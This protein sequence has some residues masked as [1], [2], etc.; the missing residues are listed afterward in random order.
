MQFPSWLSVS[1]FLFMG[2]PVIIAVISFVIW[3][4]LFRAMGW[5]IFAR[6]Q[7]ATAALFFLDLWMK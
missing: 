1:I 5:M 3:E 6:I 4:N 2:V 7:I